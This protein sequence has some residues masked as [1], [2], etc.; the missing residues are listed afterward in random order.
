[1][2]P[3][4]PTIDIGGT[5]KRCE[6]V[7]REMLRPVF[8][9]LERGPLGRRCTFLS[10]ESVGEIRALEHSAQVQ[11]L[12]GLT[13]CAINRGVTGFGKV[14]I[15]AQNLITANMDR[16]PVLERRISSFKLRFARFC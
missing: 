8:T 13:D 16:A 9:L 7:F 4:A 3:P 1:M 2:V 10:Y 15:A 5:A 6:R 14:T 12:V 11:S